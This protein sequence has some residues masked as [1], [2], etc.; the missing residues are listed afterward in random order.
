[1]DLNKVMIIGRLAGDPQVRTTQNGQNVANFGVA[2]GRRWNDRNTGEPREETEFHN[3][4]AWGKLA[5]ICSNYLRKG[6]R[7]YI[8]GRLQTRNWD[9]QQTGKKMY[10]TEIIMEN[11]IMLDSKGQNQGQGGNFQGSG[12]F[13]QTQGDNQFQNQAQGSDQFQGQNETQGQ[14]QG[15]GQPQNQNKKQNQQMDVPAAEEIPTINIDEEE[16]KDDIKVEDIP[17]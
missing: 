11:M 1:M 15:Q 16:K 10:R 13:N 4:V 6:S 2:T 14:N 8:E 7:V 5:D 12:Q 3:T 17:F 9:D